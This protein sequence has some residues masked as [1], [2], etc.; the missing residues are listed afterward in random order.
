MLCGDTHP[1]RRAMCRRTAYH[2]SCVSSART[3]VDRP[4]PVNWVLRIALP[5]QG[6][7]GYTRSTILPN[8]DCLVPPHDI[9]AVTCGSLP[10]P[11]HNKTNHGSR[12]IMKKV[13]TVRGRGEGGS[14]STA[15]A[16]NSR[17]ICGRTV[18][19]PPERGAFEPLLASS[20]ARFYHPKA[21]EFR[22][23]ATWYGSNSRPRGSTSFRRTRTLV[24]RRAAERRANRAPF[25]RASYYISHPS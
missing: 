3:H 1:T 8:N 18:S 14:V 7:L 4:Y 16:K 19:S 13:Y 17:A 9:R 20:M 23:Y 24:A 25:R 21:S 22:Y 6:L 10:P 11:P 2:F 12:L 15:Q 5:D